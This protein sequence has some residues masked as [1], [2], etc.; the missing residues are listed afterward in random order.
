VGGGK[1]R[2]PSAHGS[3]YGESGAWSQTCCRT[4]RSTP[5]ARLSI[6]SRCDIGATHDILHPETQNRGLNPADRRSGHGWDAL[7]AGEPDRR[8]MSCSTAGPKVGPAQPSVNGRSGVR[9]RY[10]RAPVPAGRLTDPQL[11]RPELDSATQQRTTW[12][13]EALNAHK[14]R[15]I[16]RTPSCRRLNILRARPIDGVRRAGCGHLSRRPSHQGVVWPERHGRQRQR[17]T[18]V[19]AMKARRW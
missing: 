13:C 8:P 12:I 7:G 2:S 17:T 19:T 16:R 4:S 5:Q 11:E 10:T 6:K 18:A 3:R 15:A 1:C 14:V 9:L